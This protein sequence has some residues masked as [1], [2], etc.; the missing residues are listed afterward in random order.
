MDHL[1]NSIIPSNVLRDWQIRVF[2]AFS[3]ER[4]TIMCMVPSFLSFA[5]MA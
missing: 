2:I 4:N 1:N 5:Y 3:I